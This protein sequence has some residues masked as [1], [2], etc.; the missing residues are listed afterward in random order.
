MILVALML[1]SAL[2]GFNI[3]ELEEKVVIEDTS[4]RAGADAELVAITSP[5]ETVCNQA[6]CRNVMKVGEDFI[7]FAFI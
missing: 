4:A 1:V 7:F 6:L 2:S 3:A 5:K